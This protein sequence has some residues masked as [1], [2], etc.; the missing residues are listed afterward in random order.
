MSLPRALRVD[1]PCLS[2]QAGLFS[3][4]LTAFLVQ[5][6]PMLQA[7]ST[8]TT[9]QLLAISVATQLRTTGTVI[10]DTLN[11]TLTTFSDAL[12]IPF[13]PSTASRWIN[14]LFFLSLIFGLAAAL[15]SILAK[16][17]IREYLKWNSSLA[18]PR[19]NILIRQL[20]IEAWED[21]QVSAVLS[22]IPILLELAMVFFLAGV[23]ILL[24]TLDDVVARVITVFVSLFLGAFAALTVLPIV[25]K[26]CP[27]KSPTA[28]ACLVAAYILSSPF[29]YVFRGIISVNVITI[30]DYITFQWHCYHDQPFGRCVWLVLTNTYRLI[31]HTWDGQWPTIARTWR[32]RDLEIPRSKAFRRPDIVFAAE[33]ELACMDVT[34]GENGAPATESRIYV[35]SYVAHALLE[36]I[37]EVSHLLRALAWVKRSSQSSEVTNYIEE[38]AHMIHPDTFPHTAGNAPDWWHSGI[39]MVANWCIFQSIQKGTLD[40]PELV[41]LS[42]QLARA[43]DRRQIIPAFR[44]ALNVRARITDAAHLYIPCTSAKFL[45]RDVSPGTRALTSVFALVLGAE[46]EYFSDLAAEA[47]PNRQARPRAIEAFGLRWK[48]PVQLDDAETWQSFLAATGSNNDTKR[49]VLRAISLD[50]LLLILDNGRRVQWNMEHKGLSELYIFFAAY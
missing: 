33:S 23:V 21:W 31:T 46:C 19:E 47:S 5:T 13:S 36:H 12:S 25:S 9:N 37:A 16:Q 48:L 32:S 22:T 49:P 14:V 7:D 3:A 17:W 30:L 24:W 15:F 26:R 41:L 18:L 43:E 39:R 40:A 28:W 34:L 2:G 38:C 6:Y 8:D 20:R 44:K 11:Q 4:I 45:L 42:G 1:L 29:L 10:A 50:I 35:S 27:Y